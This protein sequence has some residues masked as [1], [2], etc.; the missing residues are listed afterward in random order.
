MAL[1]CFDG[2]HLG[3]MAVIDR[4]LAAAGD[5]LLACVFTFTK[6][7]FAEGLMPFSVMEGCSPEE[8]WGFWSV[9][10][11]RASAI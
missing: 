5:G 2:L 1:G 6:P 7:G 11:L 3:H 9:Q 8:G 4:A 10:N